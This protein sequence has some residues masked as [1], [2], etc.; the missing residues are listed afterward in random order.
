MA[1]F[2]IFAENPERKYAWRDYEVTYLTSFK[3]IWKD[4]RKLS[5][6]VRLIFEHIK[7]GLFHAQL[8]TR[9]Q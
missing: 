5:L 6:M 8:T 2:L 1:P 4:K 3:Q 7:C 9:W